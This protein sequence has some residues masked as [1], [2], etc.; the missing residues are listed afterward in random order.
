M[1]GRGILATLFGSEMGHVEEQKKYSRFEPRPI[2]RARKP[3][4]A[5]LHV[6]ETRLVN[7]S[8]EGA[9]DIPVSILHRALPQRASE[10]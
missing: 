6:V 5:R 1:A 4:T 10:L 7:G 9:D 8:N 3:M 2:E